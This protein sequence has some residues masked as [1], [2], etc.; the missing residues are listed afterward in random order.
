[1]GKYNTMNFAQAVAMVLRDAARPMKRSEI[2]SVLE[3]TGYTTA[4][5]CPVSRVGW[6]LRDRRST[7]GDVENI[8]YGLW[9][10]K[11]SQK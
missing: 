3:S 10:F 4:A 2:W 5:G 1:V 9:A 11:P 7:H 6:A 8:S